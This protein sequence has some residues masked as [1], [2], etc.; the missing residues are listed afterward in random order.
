[1][2]DKYVG[3]TIRTEVLQKNKISLDMKVL[4]EIAFKS[5]RYFHDYKEIPCPEIVFERSLSGSLGGDI[6]NVKPESGLRIRLSLEPN[7]HA[8]FNCWME[9]R[10]PNSEEWAFLIDLAFYLSSQFSEL[11]FN[12][13]SIFF[14]DP[15]CD[16]KEEYTNLFKDGRLLEQLSR[17]DWIRKYLG[18]NLPYHKTDHS[19]IKKYAHLSNKPIQS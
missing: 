6:Y 10:G 3:L 17:I 18:V 4:K 1:M 14:N 7:N 12:T 13:N 11:I 16:Q 15:D 2:Q 8:P 5:V 19:P 9:A